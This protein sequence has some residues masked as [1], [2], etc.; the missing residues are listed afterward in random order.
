MNPE[1][2]RYYAIAQVRLETI[3]LK[4]NQKWSQDGLLQSPQGG[5]P[6]IGSEPVRND[7]GGAIEDESGV[8]PVLDGPEY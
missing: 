7:A 1:W 5:Q 2:L 8:G 6:P 4:M 3:L